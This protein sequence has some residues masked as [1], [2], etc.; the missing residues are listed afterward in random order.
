MSKQVKHSFSQSK[1]GKQ[2]LT[3]VGQTTHSVTTR[4][5]IMSAGYKVR[6]IQPLDQEAALKQGADLIGEA[7]LFSVAGALVVW[8]YDKR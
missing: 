4:M 3:S 7:F 2:I 6:S 8:E 1:L 5:T